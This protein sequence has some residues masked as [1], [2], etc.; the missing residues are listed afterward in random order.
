MSIVALDFG[1][2]RIGVAVSDLLGIT[3]RPLTVIERK[4]LDEDIARIAEIAQQRR[5][6][7]IVLGLPLNM[8]DT[9]GPQAR[10]VRR[11]AGRLRR[12][13]EMEVVL[14]DERLTTV[15]AE[16]SSS[17]G[18]EETK[19]RGGDE[20]RRPGSARGQQERRRDID[21]VAAAI[22]LQDYLTA[23]AGSDKSAPEAGE[24]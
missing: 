2:R 5:A 14:W 21:A 3:A 7:K 23:S 18:V 17:R 6:K 19:R 4:S 22:I 9:V 12:A 15:E 24:Q 11:F 10:R 16:E 13:L 8:N 20:I 1:E